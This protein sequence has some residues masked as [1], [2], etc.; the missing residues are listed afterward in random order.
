MCC[1]YK[2]VLEAMLGYD[3]VSTDSCCSLLGSFSCSTHLKL[4]PKVN[5]LKDFFMGFSNICPMFE[6]SNYTHRNMRN[7]I[8]LSPSAAIRDFTIVSLEMFIVLQKY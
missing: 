3:H 1:V 5:L 2:Y 8:V 4:T 6:F 7:N